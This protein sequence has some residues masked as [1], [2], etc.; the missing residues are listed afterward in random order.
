MLDAAELRRI[1]VHDARHTAATLMLKANVGMDKVQV[2]L[3]HSS[4]RQTVDTYGHLTAEAGAEA[5]AVVARRL[6]LPARS[7]VDSHDLP[8]VG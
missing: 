2:V 7:S 5:V 3:G 8:A 4:I 6:V 1:R